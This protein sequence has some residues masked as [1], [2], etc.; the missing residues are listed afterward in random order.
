MT[1]EPVP[2]CDDEQS[3]EKGGLICDL[4]RGHVGRH[5]K[6]GVASWNDGGMDV[7]PPELAGPNQ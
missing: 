3:D 4:L 6:R 5:Q 7:R 2:L 1:R